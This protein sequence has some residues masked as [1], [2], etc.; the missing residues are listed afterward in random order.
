MPISSMGAFSAQSVSPVVRGVIA[1]LSLAIGRNGQNARLAAKLTGW[2]ITI[3]S[4][5][6]YL[7]ERTRAIQTITSLSELPGIGEVTRERLEA[8]GIDSIEMM[9]TKTEEELTAIEGVGPKTA[10]KL[11]ESAQEWV[12]QHVEFAPVADEN[13]RPAAQ[14]GDELFKTDY[15]HDD[16]DETEGEQKPDDEQKTEEEQKTEGEQ[17]GEAEADQGTDDTTESEQDK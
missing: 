9:A 5:S 2:K 15:D 12:A 4:E 10:A 13:I 6:Q 7:N 11:L 8:G 16:D 14:V 1:P 3:R 17:Q